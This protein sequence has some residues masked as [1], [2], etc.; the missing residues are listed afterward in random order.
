M[1]PDVRKAKAAMQ[2]DMRVES[3][4]HTENVGHFSQPQK[5]G[6]DVDN[7]DVEDE[8]VCEEDNLDDGDDYDEGCSMSP[9]D[10]SSE[11]QQDY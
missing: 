9:Y 11:E 6:D 2:A 1:Q 4:P 8:K 10:C 3:F 5:T 7:D